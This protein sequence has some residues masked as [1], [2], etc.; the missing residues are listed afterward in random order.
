MRKPGSGSDEPDAHTGFLRIRSR[1]HDGDLLE[2][3]TDALV[4]LD[5]E[6][7]YTYVNR[8]AERITGELRSAML[9]R[10]LWAVFPR[11]LGTQLEDAC[12][13]SMSERI[14]VCINEYYPLTEAW[15]N[16]TV[17]PWGDGIAVHSRDITGQKR[18]EDLLR[19][20]EERYRALFEAMDQGFCL[21]QMLFNEAGEP[22][23][24]VFIETNPAFRKHVGLDNAVGRR[25]LE[26]I[27]DLEKRW[28]DAFG[29]V[30]L[31]G[32]PI[33]LES[34]VKSIGRWFDV[35]AFR[36]GQPESRKVALLF[37][38]VTKRRRVQ[39]ALFRAHEELDRRVSKRTEQLL[40]ANAQLL[41]EINERKSAEEEI[42]RA[43]AERKRLL[44]RLVF[45]E[46]QERRHIARDLHDDLAQRLAVL[47]IELD[48]LVEN[49]DTDWVSSKTKL[50][51]L[52][53]NVAELADGVRQISHR[54]HPS[55]LDVLGLEAA[56]QDMIDSFENSYDSRVEFIGGNLSRPVPLL[57]ATALYRI[58][59]AA[60]RNA[61]KYASGAAVTVTL[62]ETENELQLTVHDDGPGFDTNAVATGPGL[63]LV[64]MQERAQLVGGTLVLQ[65][66]PGDGA[67]V[68]VTVPWPK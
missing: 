26:V 27:P 7:R 36:L 41:N 22:V 42:R 21:I 2:N 25:A 3:L 17:Y 40:D 63:G 14:T 34:E 60:L 30:A 1:E 16:E 54:L 31:T 24:Y 11:V 6:W 58:S 37:S 12:R 59:Q 50:S 28:I 55:I 67:Y 19:V 18:A 8:A 20:S 39:E 44:G 64:S 38:N 32:L 43:E 57:I 66:A 65:S 61:A 45:A 52:R 9:G 49:A 23:D 13:R 5:R 46:E 35:Y 10:T 62:A 47:H 4:A 51:T 33:R 15:F 48:R 56:L 68:S 29:G 53:G